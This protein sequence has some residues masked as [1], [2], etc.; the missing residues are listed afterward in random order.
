MLGANGVERYEKAD[1]NRSDDPIWSKANHWTKKERRGLLDIRESSHCSV[2]GGN[3]QELPRRE[4]RFL[5][6]EREGGEL[7]VELQHMVFFEWRTIHTRKVG[8]SFEGV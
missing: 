6:A 5:S 7:P 4:P 8:L 3:S 2:P 1:A